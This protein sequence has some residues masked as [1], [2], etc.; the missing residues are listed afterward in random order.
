MGKHIKIEFWPEGSRAL[1]RNV[2]NSQSKLPMKT[3][4]VQITGLYLKSTAMFAI[5]GDELFTPNTVLYQ[6][7][8]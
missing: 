5:L 1:F 2:K 4:L 3:L 8:K 6:E 7:K